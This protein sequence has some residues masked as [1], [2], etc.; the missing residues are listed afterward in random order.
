MLWKHPLA[1]YVMLEFLRELSHKACDLF[2][3]ISSKVNKFANSKHQK[4]TFTKAKGSIAF[5]MGVIHTSIQ[6][7]ALGRS[8]WPEQVSHLQIF[9]S[10][11]N[12]S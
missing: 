11:S 12:L 6:S 9:Y 10:Q 4:K 7:F 2:Q 8:N 3:Q 1:P 5:N